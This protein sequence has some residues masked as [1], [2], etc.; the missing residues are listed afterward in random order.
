[1]AKEVKFEPIRNSVEK[2]TQIDPHKLYIECFIYVDIASI[3]RELKQITHAQVLPVEDAPSRARKHI[4]VNDV[5]VSTVRPNIKAVAIVKSEYHNQIASTGFCILR[6]KKPVIEAEYLFYLTQTQPFVSQMTNIANGASYPAVSDDDVLDFEVPLPSL[7]EQRRIAA[8]L[9][10]VDEERRRRRYTLTLSDNFLREIFVQ[11]FGDPVT[12]P[13]GWENATLADV[14]V[15]A[16][17]G[18]HVSPLYVDSGI[19]FLSTRNVRHGK[20]VW[21]DLKYISLEDAQIQW[22]KVKPKRGDIL[23]TKGGTTGLA[24]AVDFDLDFAVWVHI[25]VLELKL[26]RVVPIWLENMLNSE[27]CYQQSQELTMGIV[28]RDLGLQRMPKIK[29]Y[30]PPLTLQEK[31]ALIAQKYEQVQ[32]Q[33]RE[34]ARQGDHLF[35]TL[36]H[37]AF[38]GEL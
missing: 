9:R 6:A 25:A 11:M 31:F 29:L 33:Q 37:R 18:P 2:T 4:K 1:V 28:N 19:P 20:I 22:K 17:D 34:S 26:D 24:K 13:M 15:S 27:Y 14:I 12:N 3:D 32:R 36:L 5:L 35:Q 7:S 23:Y 10:A 38:R 30:I 21:E 16:K 8:I